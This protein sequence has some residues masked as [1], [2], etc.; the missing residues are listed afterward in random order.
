[1]IP[2]LTTDVGGAYVANCTVSD[3]TTGTQVKYD[4][5]IDRCSRNDSD[6]ASSDCSNYSSLGVPI[7]AGLF[8]VR[9]R[10]DRVGGGERQEVTADYRVY[11][12]E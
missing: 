6:L 7:N 9:A 11:E 5:S 12:D 2:A 1:V 8:I 4:L 3:I 10:W